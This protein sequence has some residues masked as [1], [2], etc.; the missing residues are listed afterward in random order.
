[1]EDEKHMKTVLIAALLATV[2][3][4]ACGGDDDGDAWYKRSC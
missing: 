3:A 1:L 2:L 4:M